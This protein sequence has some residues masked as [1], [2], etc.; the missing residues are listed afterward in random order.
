[1]LRT[2]RKSLNISMAQHDQLLE[3]ITLSTNTNYQTYKQM[4]LDAMEDGQID[5]DE[6]G[7]LESLRQSLGVSEYQHAKAIDDAK[8][9]KGC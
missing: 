2:L 9:Q 6:A 1:M 4:V 7:M 3:E 8:K 5:P